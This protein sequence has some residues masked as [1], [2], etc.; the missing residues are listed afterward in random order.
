MNYSNKVKELSRQGLV[1]TVW[2]LETGWHTWMMFVP[3][4]FPIVAVL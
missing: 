2:Y 4:K 1:S 3:Q